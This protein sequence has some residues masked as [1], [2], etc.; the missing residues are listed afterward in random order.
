MYRDIFAPVLF[1]HLLPSLSGANLRLGEFNVSNYPNHNFVL[2]EF[3]LG[4]GVGKP[5]ASEEQLK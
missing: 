1:S 3:K 4:V 2:G 5:F